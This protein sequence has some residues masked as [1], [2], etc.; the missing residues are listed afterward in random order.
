MT[1]Y[2]SLPEGCEWCEECQ[3]EGFIQ[4]GEW[5]AT[6]DEPASPKGYVCTACGGEGVLP[7]PDEDLDADADADVD[8]SMDGDAE[9]ALASAGF[10]TD[11]DYG[12]YGGEEF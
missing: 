10:G 5:P 9:S 2:Q 3:G 1:N 6:Q 12:G 7:D 8:D 11:E 4:T